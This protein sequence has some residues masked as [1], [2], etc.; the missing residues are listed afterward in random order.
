MYGTMNIK[1][2]CNFAHVRAD[3]KKSFNSRTGLVS[4]KPQHMDNV[5]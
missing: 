2:N 5:F 4:N 1:H 3:F